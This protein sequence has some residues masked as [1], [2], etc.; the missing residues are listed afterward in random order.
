MVTS[1]VY[2]RTLTDRWEVDPW[3]TYSKMSP[4]SGFI[5][6]GETGPW[7]SSGCHGL[8]SNGLITTWAVGFH[9]KIGGTMQLLLAKSLLV[10]TRLRKG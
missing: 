6:H 5:Q 4:P 2:T 10:Y 7:E 1:V 8:W 9:F 3:A